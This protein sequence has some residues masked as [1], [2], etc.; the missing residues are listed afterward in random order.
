MY[1]AVF[2]H[3]CSSLESIELLL[4]L[5]G[6]ILIN[7]NFGLRTEAGS[8]TFLSHAIIKNNVPLIVLLLKYGAD[9][10]G[11]ANNEYP[12]VRAI[13]D[14]HLEAAALLIDKGAHLNGIVSKDSPTLN[15]IWKN[16]LE[17]LKLLIEKGADPNYDCRMNQTNQRTCPLEYAMRGRFSQEIIDYLLSLE[18]IAL[19]NLYI[20]GNALTWA[21][22]AGLNETAQ[23]LLDEN[24]INP[25]A[26]DPSGRFACLNLNSFDFLEFLVRNGL[27]LNA[28]D[29]Q[30]NT[31]L[32]QALDKK[33]WKM[34]NWLLKAGADINHVNQHG[35]TLLDQFQSKGFFFRN[36]LQRKGA[37]LAS[38]L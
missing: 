37:R 4:K 6:K 27:N 25:S 29:A 30:G 19:E 12:L 14:N 36:R 9:P 26:L 17:A 10:N 8:R 3:H 22:N 34:V 33:D 23:K 2:Y 11:M 35:R 15:A 31:P 32:S 18:G 24:R 13:K 16:N 20:P 38:Q 7:T 5:G 1:S 28:E 21:C